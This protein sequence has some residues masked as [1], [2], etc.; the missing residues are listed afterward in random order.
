L[1]LSSSLPSFLQQD[2]VLVLLFFSLPQAAFFFFELVGS[3]LFLLDDAL[4]L[5]AA[6]AFVLAFRSG[7]VRRSA[8]PFFLTGVEGACWDSS[9]LSSLDEELEG[10]VMVKWLVL[11]CC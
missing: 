5:A 1:V 7:V 2:L 3:F 4:L 6:L 11:L 8:T 9:L 10:D